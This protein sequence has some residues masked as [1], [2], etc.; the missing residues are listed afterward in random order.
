MFVS[1]RHHASAAVQFEL[2]CFGTLGYCAPPFASFFG[3]IRHLVESS[4]NQRM[5]ALERNT[6][7]H[8]QIRGT[9]E[10]E[11]DTIDRSDCVHTIHCLAVFYLDYHKY[12]SILL[13]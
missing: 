4:L 9:H 10:Q 11:I 5:L 8:G 2:R 13:S 3:R 1:T 6:I 12:L 7:A